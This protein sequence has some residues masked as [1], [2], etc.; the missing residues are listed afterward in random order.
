MSS[1]NTPIEPDEI[2]QIRLWR[3]GD[4][5]MNGLHWRGHIKSANSKV[6]GW[7]IGLEQLFEK[8]SQLLGN[9]LPTSGRGSGR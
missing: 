2:I 5:E 6:S 4:G 8:L 9:D 7:F 3:E 1:P